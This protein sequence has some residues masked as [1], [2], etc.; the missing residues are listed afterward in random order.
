[1]DGSGVTFSP[2]YHPTP[3]E[4]TYCVTLSDWWRDIQKRDALDVPTTAGSSAISIRTSRHQRTHRLIKDAGPLAPPDGYFD[5][6][7]EVSDPT[8]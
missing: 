8:Y 5:C 7:V 3:D 4:I 2:F 6:T 1:M